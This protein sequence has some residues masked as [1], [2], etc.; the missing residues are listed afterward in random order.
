MM[1]K[2]FDLLRAGDM[3]N[4]GVVLRPA[5]SQEDFGDCVFIQTVGP[6]AV[7]RFRGDGHQLTT[8]ND[9]RR[10]GGGICILSGKV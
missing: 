6:Q 1:A 5:L 3:Q 8:A 2:K 4:E 10:D 9:F 7:D